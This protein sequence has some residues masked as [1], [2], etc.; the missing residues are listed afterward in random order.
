[1][2]ETGR[3][4]LATHAP[5]SAVVQQSLPKLSVKLSKG[6]EIMKSKTLFVATFLAAS[7]TIGGSAQAHDDLDFPVGLVT[8]VFLGLSLDHH[9]HYHGYRDRPDPYYHHREYRRHESHGYPSRERG[10]HEHHHRDSD[11]HDA[12]H[13]WD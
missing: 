1:M 10:R 2:V 12:G 3:S 4:C 8:G 5:H 7:L 9:N 6:D 11:R 13:R